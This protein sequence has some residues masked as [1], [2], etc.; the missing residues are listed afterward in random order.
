MRPLASARWTT[1]EVPAD[2]SKVALVSTEQ[3]T[4][5]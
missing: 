3:T 4:S 5:A 1:N 2:V